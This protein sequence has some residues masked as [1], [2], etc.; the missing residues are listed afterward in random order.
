MGTKCKAVR[1]KVELGKLMQGIVYV[2]DVT[3]QVV[4]IP[5]IESERKN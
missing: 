1:T 5:I 4:A 3:N 2:A